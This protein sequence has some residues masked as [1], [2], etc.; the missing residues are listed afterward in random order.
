MAQFDIYVDTYSSDVVTG[1]SNPTVAS[2]PKFV[3]GDTI[4]LRIYL[5]ARTTGGNI[6]STPYTIISTAGIALKVALGPKDG[7]AG[8]TLLTQQFTWTPDASQQYFAATLPLNTAGITAA[9]GS[10]NSVSTWFEI[11]M[12]QG[13]F[14]TTVLQK[15]AD[16][17]AEV[18]ETG[19]IA[20]PPGQTAIS[21]EEAYAV[22]LKRENTGFFLKNEN[23]GHRV[24]VYLGDDD[25]VHMDPVA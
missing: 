10:A 19:V 22:F 2:L 15:Q 17:Q 1:P 4:S 12:T 18:I 25:A 16:I 13:G 21:A 11:E 5:L 7:T 8:S 23:T 24:F 6:S 20:T 3:Q 14:P 9:I